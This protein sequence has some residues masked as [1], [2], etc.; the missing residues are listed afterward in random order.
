MTW[1]GR[2]RL[3]LGYWALMLSLRLLPPMD[4]LLRVAITEI[5]RKELDVSS[6]NTTAQKCKPS[7]PE[8]NTGL[9]SEA[10]ERDVI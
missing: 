9:Q 4:Y 6:L 5:V 10:L 8:G 3:A 7:Q 1:F 2:I